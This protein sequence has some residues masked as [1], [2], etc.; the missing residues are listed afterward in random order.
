GYGGGASGGQYSQSTLEGGY[1]GGGI[2]GQHTQTSHQST[3]VGGTYQGR[4]QGL[5]GQPSGPDNGYHSCS[6]SN[7]Q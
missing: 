3:Y 4:G 6:M 2:G 7:G 5:C 1:G